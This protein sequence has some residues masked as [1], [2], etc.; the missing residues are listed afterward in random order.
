MLY[1][2][3]CLQGGIT[4]ERIVALFTFVGDVAVHQ[5][6]HRGEQFLSVLLK[7]SFRYLVDHICKWVQEA[8]G[9]VSRPNHVENPTVL[10]LVLNLRDGNI[11][12]VR[13][14]VYYL[15][16]FRFKVNRIYLDC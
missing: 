4:R 8:G 11:T 6:R 5:V 3:L 15:C 10:F 1:E 14:F 7:W 12:M 2:N 16:K 9:W 13:P